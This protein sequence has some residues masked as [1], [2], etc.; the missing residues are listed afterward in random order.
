[1]L[2]KFHVWQTHFNLLPW[3]TQSLALKTLKIHTNMLYDPLARLNFLV[4]DDVAIFII[5][6]L[7]KQFKV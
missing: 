2:T 6:I 3:S 1:M 5:R 7:I 4:A